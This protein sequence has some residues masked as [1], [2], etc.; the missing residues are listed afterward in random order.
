MQDLIGTEKIERLPIVVSGGGKFKLLG[1]PK[2][3]S[4]TCAEIAEAVVESLQDWNI[5]DSVNAMCFDTTASN[6]GACVTIETK[7]NRSL[8]AFGCRH[9]VNE[10]IV[11]DVFKKCFGNSYGPE[12]QLFKCFRDSWKNINTSLYETDKTDFSWKEEVLSFCKEHLKCHQPR[13]D[14]R[15]LL[16]LSI[17]YLGGNAEGFSF[18]QP[19]AVHRA[20]WMAKVIY[21][22][23]IV[24]FKSQFKM[25]KKEQT[26]IERFA[27]FVVRYYVHNWFVAPIASTA[28]RKDLEY[29]QSLQG[30]E[31]KELSSVASRAL[32]RHV[33]YLSEELV[34]LAFMDDG[35]T[36]DLKRRMIAALQKPGSQ[37]PE[38][39]YKL[40]ERESISNKTLADFVTESSRFALQNS[41]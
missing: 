7:L 28:P 3:T 27:R 11:S 35:I 20:R 21:S 2:L 37:H 9:H 6:T 14:Y 34:S 18:R 12:I 19:G 24:L 36:L 32:G 26:S 40:G 5:K 38:K 30:C 31:D 8:L 13:A 17:A 1:I 16:Q 15:E 39:R 10:I 22:I 41:F 29:L 23:K 33:W 4:G 25:P